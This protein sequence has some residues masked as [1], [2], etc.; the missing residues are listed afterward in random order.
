MTVFFYFLGFITAVYCGYILVYAWGW[1]RQKECLPALPA[2]PNNPRPPVTVVIPLRNEAHNIPRL[3]VSLQNQ[4]YPALEVILVDD[5]STDASVSLINTFPDTLFTLLAAPASGKKAALKHGIEH[6]KGALILTTDADVTLP[7]TWVESMVHA[8]Y[9]TPT[10][11]LIGPVTMASG[12][13]WQQ[14]EH[15]SLEGTT[16][17]SAAMGCPVLCSGANLAFTPQ[18]YEQ[19]A[20]F[21]QPNVPSGDDMFLLEATLRQKGK[22]RALKSKAA[23][24]LI[25]GEPTIQQFLWQR[26]RWAGKAPR[27]TQPSVWCSAAVVALMQVACL[28][29][30][31]LAPWY[32]FLLC[33]ILCKFVVDALLVGQVTVYRQK[34]SQMWCFPL[35][36]LLY[37]L[38]VLVVL[39]LS[40]L[41]QSWKKRNI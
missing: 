25:H 40:L 13:V 35:L 24:V 26:A 21:L 16:V 31:I 7:S 22:V 1:H 8:F 27:Y 14:V 5:H 23:T 30:L 29:V 9:S 20:P 33:V 3:L 38:Y 39:C 34:A 2:T 17:G 4:T 19:C 10:Q 6:A 32:P 41:P 37:P 28:A 15:A 36:T 18:W 12:S 11:L